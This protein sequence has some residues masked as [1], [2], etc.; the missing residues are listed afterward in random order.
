ML[1]EHRIHYM[2][3]RRAG[4]LAAM[5]KVFAD[6]EEA[7]RLIR[8]ER[9]TRRERLEEIARERRRLAQEELL[10]KIADIQASTAL[11]LDEV[12]ALHPCGRLRVVHSM[13][14]H[15]WDEHIPVTTEMALAAGCSAAD[16]D[17]VTNRLLYMKRRAERKAQEKATRALAVQAAATAN[18]TA[19]AAL[20]PDCLI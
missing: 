4:K 16:I 3:A 10:R 5:R 8:L 11:T 15:Y 18:D 7:E 17:W 19:Q 6:K 13:L 1:L 12:V 9:Q 2:Q 14:K 20:I